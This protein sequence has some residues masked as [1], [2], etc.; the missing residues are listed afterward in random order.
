MI[1]VISIT[2]CKC[3]KCKSVVSNSD[4]FCKECG[5]NLSEHITYEELPVIGIRHP[6]KSIMNPSDLTK[7]PYI[8]SEVVH[9]EVDV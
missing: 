4:K 1:K 2:N 5:N 7:P 9:N 3:E 8:T 6:D